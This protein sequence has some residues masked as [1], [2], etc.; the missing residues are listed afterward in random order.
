[1]MPKNRMRLFCD[2]AAEEQNDEIATNQP[3]KKFDHNKSTITLAA[4]LPAGLLLVPQLLAQ[5]QAARF[6]LVSP[7]A[8]ALYYRTCFSEAS[9]LFCPCIPA[10]SSASKIQI[11]C[12]PVDED[13]EDASAADDDEDDEESSIGSGSGSYQSLEGEGEDLDLDLAGGLEHPNA[14]SNWMVAKRQQFVLRES[15]QSPAIPQLQSKVRLLKL[16]CQ[17]NTW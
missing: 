15:S 14:S 1:M 5:S 3:L 9:K 17:H 7:D 12:T 6:P 8:G 16:L 10:P 13:E 4:P 2:N 11:P